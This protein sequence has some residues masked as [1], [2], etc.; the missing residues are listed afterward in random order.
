MAHIKG[1]SVADVAAQGEIIEDKN[2]DVISS[3]SKHSSFYK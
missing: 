2:H 3:L 1:V